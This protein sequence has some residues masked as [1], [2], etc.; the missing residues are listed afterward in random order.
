MPTFIP[1]DISPRLAPPPCRSLLMPRCRHAHAARKSPRQRDKTRIE[2]FQKT[3]Q[4]AARHPTIRARQR[5][6]CRASFADVYARRLR[7]R[8]RYADRSTPRA[9]T[10]RL[11]RKICPVTDAHAKLTRAMRCAAK[12]RETRVQNIAARDAR[13]RTP[14]VRAI[15][16]A[17]DALRAMMRCAIRA[18]AWRTM[19]IREPHTSARTT[20]I[21]IHAIVTAKPLSPRRKSLFPS[22][23]PPPDG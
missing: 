23:M 4:H 5:P 22:P 19:R 10:R 2:S 16:D 7:R 18:S 12:V 17:H 21:H 20:V 1:I 14:R 3:A 6:V 11:T 8:A 15:F 13:L 9:M